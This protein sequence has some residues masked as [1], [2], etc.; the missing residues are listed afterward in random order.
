[1]QKQQGVQQQQGSLQGATQGDLALASVTVAG[2]VPSFSSNRGF[3]AIADTGA[4]VVTLTLSDAQAL[5]TAGNVQC[6]PSSAIYAV[7][8]VE[9][10]SATSLVVRT[11]DAAGMALDNI[12]F[13]IRVTPIAPN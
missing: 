8:T 11:W 6:T 4:G 2:G 3:S 5:T 10:A 12:S 13:W 9:V 1:M 7:C